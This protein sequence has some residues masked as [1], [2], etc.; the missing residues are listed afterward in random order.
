MKKL[1]ATALVLL[2]PAAAQAQSINAQEGFYI[3]AGGGAAWFLGSNSNTQ[4]WTGWAAGGKVGY[5]FVGPRLELE[6]GYGQIPTSA[7]IPGTAINGKVGQLTVMANILYDFMP[8]SVITPYI[9][10]GAGIAF[11][12]GTSSLGST[13]FAYQGMLGVAYNV[14]EQLRFMV[15]GRYVGTTNPN[16][17][18]PFGNVSFQNQNILALVGVSYKFTAPPPPPPMPQ[19]IVA[20]PS[21]MVFFDWDRSNLSA[22]ALTTIKQAAGAYKNKGNARVT[23]TGH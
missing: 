14:S 9:G 2:T 20:P 5:D 6:A 7:N 8:T 10:A 12:D 16:V 17:N 18:T 3:G 13:Q 15:E 22:Q 1:L 19:Q 23:A 4:T 21:F 11:V